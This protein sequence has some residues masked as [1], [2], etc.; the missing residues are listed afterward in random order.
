MGHY[1]Y[2]MHVFLAVNKVLLYEQICQIYKCLYTLATPIEQ[3]TSR[4]NWNAGAKHDKRYV[5]HFYNFPAS[6]LIM[7][8]YVCHKYMFLA[9]N[10]GPLC[11]Q[12]Y[13]IYIC[14][15][16]VTLCKILLCC[17]CQ[18]QIGNQVVMHMAVS[19]FSC[20]KP[21]YGVLCIS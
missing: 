8:H 17:F 3:F 14:L 21:C 2:H 15:Y 12:I 5:W 6:N 16:F 7:G 10:K 19:S 11:D 9:G 4:A 13:Q 1:V 20:I 18:E